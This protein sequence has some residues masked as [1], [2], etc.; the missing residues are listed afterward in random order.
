MDIWLTGYISHEE[1][2]RKASQVPVGSRVFQYDETRTKNLGV[3]VA[4]LHPLGELLERVKDWE[5]QN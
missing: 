1:F 3:Q 4:E 5:A 2:R